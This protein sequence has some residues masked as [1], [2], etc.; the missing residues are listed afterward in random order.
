V[1]S[2]VPAGS[3]I[4]KPPQPAPAT[5]KLLVNNLPKIFDEE[6]VRKFLKTFGRIKSLEMIKDPITG[7]YSGQCHVEYE[8]EKSTQDAL[9]CN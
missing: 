5:S 4:N 8:T 7:N 3:N 2:L 9:H 1:T 6:A